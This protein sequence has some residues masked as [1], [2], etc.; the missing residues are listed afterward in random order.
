M[1]SLFIAIVLAGSTSSPVAPPVDPTTVATGPV[2]VEPIAEPIARMILA[3]R[4]G[5]NE[6]ALAA[7][8]GLT[9]RSDFE[10]QPLEVR[11]GVW[12]MIGLL[13][14]ELGRHEAAI[15]PL[16]IASRLPGADAEIWFPLMDAQVRSERWDD[17]AQTLID[18]TRLTP[19][20]LDEVND[21][22]VFQLVRH[23]DVSAD[24]RFAVRDALWEAK[25]SPERPSGFWLAYIDGLLERE[26]LDRALEVLPSVTAPSSRVQLHALHRYGPLLDQAGRPAFDID[27]AFAADLAADRAAAADPEADLED[28]STLASSLMMAGLYEE[29]LGVAEAALALPRPTK[30]SEDWRTLTWI[31]D[32]RSRLLM[33]LGRHEEALAQMLEGSR[34]V[35]GEAVNVSQTINLGWLY[36]RLGRN[37]DALATVAEVDEDDVSPFGRMQAVQ[38]AA[39]AAHAMG[40]TAAASKSFAYLAEHWRDAPGAAYDALACRGDVDGMAALLVRRLGDADM[41]DDALAGLHTYLPSPSPTDFDARLIS[42]SEEVVRRPDVVAARDRVGRVLII[43]VLGGLF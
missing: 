28:R 7:A 39:C 33:A 19:R 37:A 36:L 18:L 29:G 5:R 40:D 13:N 43:P 30:D 25:W 2:Q 6:D 26:R 22:Y 34:R 27:A 41:A 20:V 4:E 3:L 24:K 38:V 42:L 31:M 11:R 12:H 10:A 9:G 23:P 32:T 8:K 15:E 17:A 14:A 16:R 35:E 21:D 1:Y